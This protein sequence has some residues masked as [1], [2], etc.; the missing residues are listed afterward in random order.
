MK[1]WEWN[2]KKSQKNHV[3]RFSTRDLLE[4]GIHLYCMLAKPLILISG[5]KWKLNEPHAPDFEVLEG[6]WK[7]SAQILVVSSP[8]RGI[9]VLVHPICTLF[10]NS[11]NLNNYKFM[12]Q[13]FE[14]RES[15]KSNLI[16]LLF[17]LFSKFPAYV[18]YSPYSSILIWKKFSFL[19]C[20]FFNNS[21][22]ELR[23]E[24]TWI[25]LKQT[26]NENNLSNGNWS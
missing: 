14:I 15:C 10:P 20:V 6:L 5:Q 16:F 19:I 18:F 21:Q 11:E 17:Q 23:V 9:P 7:D 1:I 2:T 13:I 25:D 22:L 8:N 26:T 12:S 3:S 24:L 4:H